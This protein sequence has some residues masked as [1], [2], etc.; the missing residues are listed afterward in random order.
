[1]LEIL[2]IGLKEATGKER[3]KLKAVKKNFVSN[4]EYILDYRLR[5]Q[6]LG[7]DCSGFR[8]LGSVESNVGKFKS[9]VRGRAWSRKGIYALGNVFSRSW[10]V[11]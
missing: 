10:M 5:L 6:A 9:R 2:D 7:Y 8:G 4:W 3:N 11:R 1:M